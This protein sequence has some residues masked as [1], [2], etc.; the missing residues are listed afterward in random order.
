V[1]ILALGVS[2][3]RAPV[4]LLERLA[5]TAEDLPK[6]YRR[7]LDMESVTEGALLST[8]NRVEVYAEVSSYHPGFLD[9][10]R[11]L[12]ESREVS[13]EEFAEPMYAHY[14]DD[15]AEH[16]FSVASGLDS[17][18][19]GE[20]QIL[21]QVRQA[22]RTSEVEGATGPSLARLFRS[23]VRAGRRVRAETAIGASPGAMVEAGIGLA[24]R[25]VGP[26]AGRS[27]LVVGAGGMASL[28]AKELRGRGIGRLRIL[29]RSP[30]RAG[31]LAAKAGGEPGGLESLAGAVASSDVIVSSTGAPG[32]VIG[33]ATVEQ[34]THEDGRPRFF[35]DLAVPR[36][37]DPA[38][39]TLPWVQ[40]ADIDDLR[41]AV[42][43]NAAASEEFARARAIVGE[44]VRRFSVWR[45][46]AKLAPLIEALRD[47][48][49][50]IQAGELSRAAPRLARLSDREWA[51]V[52]ALASGIVAKLLHA[53]IVRLK[54]RQDA[55]GADSLAGALAD[56]FDL[57]PPPGP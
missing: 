54:E 35:L 2:Y 31:R 12:A 39:A 1:P 25:S 38:V 13:P 48:G 15:V 5:F 47:R 29:N 32:T 34:A 41:E 46:A 51:A 7:L 19:L 57:R 36:D 45:R 28:A 53:P 49:A 9:L 33:A 44:E 26:L 24:E 18:V 4:E 11:F 30:E 27:A 22:Y 8:C 10:K 40:V 20:P 23:A 16:L 21:A 43:E 50:R 14:E 17:M 3:R 52:E 55:G 37:V 6:S 42:G 56:L